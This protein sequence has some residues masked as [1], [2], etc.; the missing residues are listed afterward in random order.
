MCGV[1]QNKIYLVYSHLQAYQLSSISGSTF[2]N[3]ILYKQVLQ[4]VWS[5]GI[6]LWGC[7]SDSIIQ[8]IQCFQ[9][10]VSF[11]QL[12]LIYTEFWPSQALFNKK[13]KNIIWEL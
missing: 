5:Y 1:C 3:L 12:V 11:V 2:S 10:K 6:Q 4:P 7:A 13:K 8:V 9:Y